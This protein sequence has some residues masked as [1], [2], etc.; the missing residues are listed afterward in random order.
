MDV[1]VIVPGH[2]PPADKDAVREVRD[3]LR[4]V[5]EQ[6]RERHARGMTPIEAARDI[7]L[8]RWADWG[9]GERLV[10]NVANVYS[11]IDGREL[12]VVELFGAMAELDGFLR[13]EGSP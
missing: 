3:Y 10:V 7:A 2:G 8:D 6:A 1:D 11:E 4:Y 13:Q 5:E 12:N 9:E